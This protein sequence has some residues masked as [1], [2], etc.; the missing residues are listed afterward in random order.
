MLIHR[1]LGRDRES[2][3]DLVRAVLGPLEGAR[4][5][6]DALV[7][8]VRTYLDC[9]AVATVAASRLHLS[10]RAVTYRLERVAELTG[11]DATD[12]DDR[13]TLHAAVR[14]AALLGWPQV[15]LPG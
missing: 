12:P 15:Q 10:V 13:F 14:G 5:G 8:T 1:V 6:A 2:L 7:E 4:G 9:G 11:Y 3:G